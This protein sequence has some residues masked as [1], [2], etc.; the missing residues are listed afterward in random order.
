MAQNSDKGRHYEG[1]PIRLS[2][3]DGAV[4]YVT[5]NRALGCGL[6]KCAFDIFD[7]LALILPAFKIPDIKSIQHKN[8]IKLVTDE[9]E[10]SEVLTR[11]GLLH[12]GHKEVI[13]HIGNTDTPMSSQDVH[14]SVASFKSYVSKNFKGMEKE[15]TYVIEGKFFERAIEDEYRALF[16][17]DIRIFRD[18]NID[19]NDMRCWEP[20]L[21]DFIHDIIALHKYNVKLTEDSVNYALVRRK[22]V[23]VVTE[24]TFRYF[25]FD[26][27]PIRNYEKMDH[28]GYCWNPNDRNDYYKMEGIYRRI[29][30]DAIN[31]LLSI[32]AINRHGLRKHIYGLTYSNKL[33]DEERNLGEKIES[34]F[35]VKIDEA[36]YSMA[37]SNC[38]LPTP[39]EEY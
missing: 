28:S 37:D 4:L 5:L 13:V 18:P 25:G 24:Y 32:V 22:D 31:L 3:A 23:S 30:P 17:D 33:T 29:M 34:Y 12:P 21:Q 7:D 9:L 16:V 20:V 36:Y 26:F 10:M 27:S 1:V 6:H 19:I 38:P 15:G 14:E 35:K 8:W 11:A 39:E 2:F